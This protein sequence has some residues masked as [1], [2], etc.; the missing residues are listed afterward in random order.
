MLP[1]FYPIRPVPCPILVIANS[2]RREGN[3]DENER[4]SSRSIPVVTV[5]NAVRSLLSMDHSDE[6]SLRLNVDGFQPDELNISIR[7][8]QLIVRG[9]NVVR[10]SMPALTTDSH[11]NGNE[12]FEPDFIAREFKRTFSLPSNVDIRKAH[13]QFDLHQRLLMIK[14]PFQHIDNSSEIRPDRG[15]LRPIEIFLAIVANLSIDRMFHQTDEQFLNPR[16][17]ELDEI[18][19]DL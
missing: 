19:I 12:D 6:F 15:H 11:L 14:I 3:Q 13:A 10:T 17:A 9:R 2:N 5:D 8:G 7:Q 16:Q 18:L 1:F 4:F